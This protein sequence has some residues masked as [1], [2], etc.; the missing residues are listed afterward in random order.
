MRGTHSNIHTVLIDQTGTVIEFQTP[1]GSGWLTEPRPQV[2]ANRPT[3]KGLHQVRRPNPHDKEWMGSVARTHDLCQESM[4]RR[5]V[6]HATAA[7][8]P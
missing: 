8:V 5:R 4:S 7:A 1:A 3:A 6:C 2:T